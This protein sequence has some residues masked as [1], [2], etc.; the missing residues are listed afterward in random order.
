M[1]ISFEDYINTILPSFLSN[2][3][4]RAYFKAFADVAKQ[5]FDRQ[6]FAREEGMIYEC[7]DDALTYHFNNS[8]ALVSPF[9]NFT[10]MREYLK[11][12]WEKLAKRMGSVEL[13]VDELKRFGFPRAKVWTWTD[14]ILAGVPHAF[15]GNWTLFAGLAANGGMRYLAKYPTIEVTVQHVNFGPNQP[16]TVSIGTTGT[17][18]TITISLQTD[19]S[20]FPLSTPLEIFQALDKAGANEYM[21]YNWQGTGMGR[22]AESLPAI[23]PTTYHSYFIIDL[24]APNAI[25]DPILWNDNTIINYSYPTLSSYESFWRTFPGPYPADINSLFTN[26]YDI[27]AVAGQKI[28]VIGRDETTPMPIYFMALWNGSSWTRL[29]ST[30]GQLDVMYAFS[31]NN[32]WAFGNRAMHWDGITVT[33]IPYPLLGGALQSLHGNASNSFW[34][35]SSNGGILHYDGISFSTQVS[36]VTSLN[37][38]FGFAA[39]DAWAIGNTDI[40]HYN[41]TNWTTSTPPMGIT[42]PFTSIWGSASNDVYVGNNNGDLIHWNGATWSTVAGYT[43]GQITNINGVSS[44]NMYIFSY[45]G[46]TPVL[47][48]Y[49]GV[50]FSTP[51]PLYRFSPYRTAISVS[52]YP[53][54]VDIWGVDYIFGSQYLTHN[55][56]L[57][58]YNKYVVGNFKTFQTL[59]AGTVTDMSSDIKYNTAIAVQNNADTTG[60][61]WKWNGT[62]FTKLVSAPNKPYNGVYVHE[63]FS[64]TILETWVCGNDG[65]V[66][67]FNGTSF[68]DFSY[69]TNKWNSITLNEGAGFYSVYVVGEDAM[70]NPVSARIPSPFTGGMWGSI[71]VPGTDKLNKI[72]R[73]ESNSKLPSNPEIY[74]CG[75]GGTVFRLDMGGWTDLMYPGTGDLTGLW[76]PPGSDVIYVVG[77]N[78]EFYTYNPNAMTPWQSVSTGF[79]G[80]YIGIGGLGYDEFWITQLGKYIY[81]D[82]KTYTQ[83]NAPDVTHSLI[84]ASGNSESS[85]FAFT[86]HPMG[87]NGLVYKLGPDLINVASGATGKLWND[88]WHWDGTLLADKNL[89]N[90]LRFLIR[91]YKPS[92]TSCRFVRIENKGMLIS[93]PIGEEYEEDPFGNISGPYLFSYLVP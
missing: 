57:G 4:G 41:G 9:E 19:G 55:E 43:N 11:N 63:D 31:E 23:L 32:V 20:S 75:N 62:N 47:T 42:G 58:R 48:Y 53:T 12:R 67:Y 84:G 70:G 30:S 49:N 3:R 2:D 87:G 66:M 90:E 89:M 69:T 72:I 93:S 34:L 36:G 21:Y 1:A 35:V 28:W 68:T 6:E 26:F 38:V 85:M 50:T 74:A 65:L 46:D 77:T 82:G 88:G 7:T 86:S 52:N 76:S 73:T 18:A 60:S 80:D 45:K 40:I 61:V 56:K 37:R 33:T 51:E 25:S 71:M 39:N 81:F 79:M 64:G 27:S 5:E 24:Y 44:G 13:L 17:T 59:D 14:L 8:S 22:A 10:Q 92:T 15:G 29:N 54:D 91:K 16:L 78:N 83:I